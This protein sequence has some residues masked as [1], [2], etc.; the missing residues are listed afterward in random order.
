MD[1]CCN[2]EH[3]W[4]TQVMLL[5]AVAG[6]GK[7]AVAHTIAGLCDQRGNLLSSFFFR[8]GEVTSPDYL[9]SGVARSLA[10]RSQPYCMILTSTLKKDPSLATTAFDEQFRELVLGPLHRS[11]PWDFQATAR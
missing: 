5:T 4:K 10:I 6:A 7:S 9:W 3:H 1:W 11:G 2:L 8:A